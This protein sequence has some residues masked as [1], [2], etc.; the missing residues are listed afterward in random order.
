MTRTFIGAGETLNPHRWRDQG[1]QRTFRNKIS[2]YG[3]YVIGGVLGNVRGG[4]GRR[5]VGL[6]NFSE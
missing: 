1:H 5:G 6:D 2:D 4:E 3:K